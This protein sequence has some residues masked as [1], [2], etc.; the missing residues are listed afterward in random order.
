[1]KKK[2][3]RFI[4]PHKENFHLLL[5]LNWKKSLHHQNHSQKGRKLHFPSPTPAAKTRVRR[6]FTRSSTHKE[7]VETEVIPKASVPKK[8]KGKGDRH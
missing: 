6:P 3:G 7:V 4:T 2:R 5:H 1:L 8:V